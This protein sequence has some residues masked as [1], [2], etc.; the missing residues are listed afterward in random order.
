VSGFDVAV[1]GAGIHGASA[2]YHL[3]KDGARTVIFDRG[4]PASGPT[5][6]SSAVCRAYYTNP[7]L[8]GVARDSIRMMANFAELTGA[9]S[10]YRNTGALFLHSAEDEADVRRTVIR[11]NEQDIPTQVLTPDEIG[12]RFPQFDLSGIGV[13]AWEE[14][15]GYADPTGTTLG[16]FGRAVD[17]GV[18]SRLGTT[19]VGL[20]P[21]PEGGGSVVVADGSRTEA[22][23]IL[24]AAGPWTRPLAAHVG[25]DLP[26]T[27]ER[28][29][30]GTFRWGAA[31]P[32]PLHADVGGGYYFKPEGT[33]LYLV[34]PLHQAPQADP[35]RFSERIT[36]AEIHD[37]SR[38]VVRR[39]PQLTRSETQGGWASLYD[40]SP[41]WQPVIGEITTGVFVD[42]GTSG[43]GFKLGPALG[44]HVAAMILGSVPD[45]GI[46]AFH[47]RRFAERRALA[48]GYGAARIL[49]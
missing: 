38:R 28:H 20:D 43:H 26:L 13:G 19:V 30:V 35:D 39:V 41:D 9:D 45:P 44:R 11:L 49:G 23:A 48:A 24:I 31:D 46:E 10:G 15:A 21:R 34:G 18:E 14:D 1:I 32:M 16:L 22:D 4:T 47:P 8:A 33:D 27:V 40:V 2:A 36:P 6:R 3:S 29:V 37:L 5:G 12:E 7:F 42:A 17:Q 25:V